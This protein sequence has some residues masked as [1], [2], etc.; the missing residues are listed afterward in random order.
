MC[1]YVFTLLRQ[2]YRTIFRCSFNLIVVGCRELGWFHSITWALF[3]AA[4]DYAL[5][6]DFLFWTILSK[7][8]PDWFI[9]HPIN[10]HLHLVNYLLLLLDLSV[11]AIEIRLFHWIHG[12]LFGT[13][14]GLFSLLLHLTGI[15]SSVYPIVN[16]KESPGMAVLVFVLVGF[17]GG[18][19]AQVTAYCVF[20]LRTSLAKRLH[21]DPF[22]PRTVQSCAS[23]TM[24]ITKSKVRAAVMA[25]I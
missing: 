9:K 6:V 12:L 14:Y 11:S 23:E 4:Y 21:V 10:Y 2:Q 15:E 19:L 5:V 24:Q 20:R 13:A 1:P 17:V 18:P 7:D 25:W 3:N 16:W 8:A 22:S